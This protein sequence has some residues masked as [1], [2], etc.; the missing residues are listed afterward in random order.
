LSL[1]IHDEVLS[2]GVGIRPL[3]EIRF[4]NIIPVLRSIASNYKFK[5]IKNKYQKQTK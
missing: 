5:K 3:L 1:A 2:R 4:G